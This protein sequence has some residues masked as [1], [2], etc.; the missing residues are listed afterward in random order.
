MEAVIAYMN[1][2]FIIITL[3]VKCVF[4]VQFNIKK[5]QMAAESFLITHL[6]R[7]SVTNLN[8]QVMYAY[9]T[10]ISCLFFGYNLVSV[11]STSN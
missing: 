7:S 1:N 10:K 9:V 2:K 5:T 8:K 4:P 11:A 3:N 6:Y